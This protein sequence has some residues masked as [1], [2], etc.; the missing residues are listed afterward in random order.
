MTSSCRW[1]P[2]KGPFTIE[3]SRIKFTWQINILYSLDFSCSTTF[4]CWVWLAIFGNGRRWESWP[5]RTVPRSCGVT[6]HAGWEEHRAWYMQGLVSFK[7]QLYKTL[8]Q[9][10]EWLWPCNNILHQRSWSPLVLVMAHYQIASACCQP[11]S[12]WL[13]SGGLLDRIM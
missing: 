5:N 7:R 11:G 8:S 4:G 2:S 3:N 13:P 6:Q 9:D 1:N 12:H 10:F